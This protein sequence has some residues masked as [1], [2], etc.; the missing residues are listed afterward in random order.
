MVVAR[1]DEAGPAMRIRHVL[2]TVGPEVSASLLEAQQYTLDSIAMAI[3]HSARRRPDVVIEVV[4]A[5]FAD[6]PVAAPWL[7][8]VDPIERSVVDV[9]PLSPAR[10]LPLLADVLD[11]LGDPDDY[12]VGVYTNIDIGVQPYFYDLVAETVASGTDGFVI[13]RRTVH[14]PFRGASL[15]AVM[16][17]AGS[18]HPGHD[19]F[20][21]TARAAQRFELF[22]VCI[23]APHVGRMLLWNVAATSNV[24]REFVDLH[25]TFHLGDDRPW[26]SS[27]FSEYT[28]HNGRQALALCSHL[29]AEHG[30]ER[31]TA[32]PAI[33]RYLTALDLGVPI[34]DRTGEARVRTRPRTTSRQRLVFAAHPGRCGSNYLADLMRLIPNVDAHH[35]AVPRMTG[36]ILRRVVD[37]GLRATYPDRIHKVDE[38]RAKLATLPDG[39]VHLDTSHMFVKTMADVILDAFNH[40]RITVLRIHRSPA[41]LLRSFLELGW[42]SCRNSYWQDWAHLPITP[43]CPFR[44]E[45]DVQLDESDLILGYLADVEART[46]RVL[47]A[48]PMVK[49]VDVAFDR[50]TTVRGVER[51][52]RSLDLPFPTAA[53]AFVGTQVNDKTRNKEAI[54]RP[55]DRDWCVERVGR[56]R[57]EFAERFEVAGLDDLW[58]DHLRIDDGGP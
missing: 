9:A 15:E 45:P 49:V 13:N 54:G 16:A 7:T 14:P 32:L 56:F 40:D 21:F 39:A 1:R 50:L 48:A 41:D 42:F 46:R 3:E 47:E 38:L 23:G 30:R 44:L 11:R 37:E 34:E 17:Q 25:A 27:R 53:R 8:D 12:D 5:R 33:R 51:M 26:R 24:F 6:E 52:L 18:L 35:E 57:K 19:C 43:H 20:V 2:P 58:V 4:A 55:I 10:R 31:V 22:D 29:I 36:A 28:R